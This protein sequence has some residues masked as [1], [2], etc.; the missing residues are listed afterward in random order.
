MEFS[1]LLSLYYKEKSDYL[2]QSLDSIFNQTLKPA[3]VILVEDGPLTK[4]LYMVVDDTEELREE[5]TLKSAFSDLPEHII[6]KWLTEDWFI[7]KLKFYNI[8]YRDYI[9]FDL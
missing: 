1:V 6:R 5:E 9:K 2:R 4:E 7:K 3:E 8:D